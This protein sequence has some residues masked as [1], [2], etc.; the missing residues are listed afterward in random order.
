MIKIRLSR[1]TR[2]GEPFYRIVATDERKAVR[3]AN[4]EIL[5]FWNPREKAKKV[6]KKGIEAWV[7]KGAQISP[8]VQ[9]LMS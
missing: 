5:G 7:A 3:G 4:L 9:K 2:K 8:A 6:D 1:G